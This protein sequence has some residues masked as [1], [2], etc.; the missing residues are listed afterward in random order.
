MK[1]L[2]SLLAASLLTAGAYAQTYAPQTLGTFVGAAQ[3]ATNVAF[4]ID[5]RKQASVTLQVDNIM[6]T[7]ATDVQTVAIARSVDGLTYST[8]LQAIAVTPV[9][10]TA[11]TMFTNLPTYGCGYMKIAY[12]TNA[13]A[14]GIATN[15]FKYGIKIS[16]P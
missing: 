13:A 14:T 12:V 15:T 2:V 1:K 9:A 16:A 3:A 4:V 5:C 7:S 11:S 10:S 8:T 6:S